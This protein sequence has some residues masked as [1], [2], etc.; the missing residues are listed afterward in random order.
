M[1]ASPARLGRADPFLCRFFFVPTTPGKAFS[2]RSIR[3]DC[4]RGG[5]IRARIRYTRVLSGGRMTMC[6]ERVE[7]RGCGGKRDERARRYRLRWPARPPV[8]APRRRVVCCCRP[9]ACYHATDNIKEKVGKD[10][11]SALYTSL[12]FAPGGGGAKPRRKTTSHPFHIA[13]EDQT[14]R[15]DDT[16]HTS[17]SAVNVTY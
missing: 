9:Y 11:G 15:K 13:R 17:P 1:R 2:S 14:A 6:A 4:M 3:L 12:L 10:R 8:C 5:G 7:T 16:K